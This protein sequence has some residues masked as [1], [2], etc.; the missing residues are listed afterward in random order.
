[1]GWLSI[2]LPAAVAWL[3][4]DVPAHRFLV[5]AWLKRGVNAIRP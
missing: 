1:M 5:V 4:N 3:I 2:R